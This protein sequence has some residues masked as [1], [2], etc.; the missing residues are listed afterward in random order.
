VKVK[1]ILKSTEGRKLPIIREDETIRDV[2]K[3][4]LAHPHTRLIY[5]VDKEGTYVGAISLGALIRH[6]FPH[7]YEPAVHPRSLLRMVTSETAKDIMSKQ[8]MCATHEESVEAVIERMIKAK[9]KEI[10]I[11]NK[12]KK[13][14]AD[15]TMLDLLQ[16]YHLPE[17]E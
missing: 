8:I 11:V 6:V 12:E 13:I 4:I 9:I 10:A 14:I 1:D 2:L 7:F 15:V 17:D 16:Y 3:K 5:V